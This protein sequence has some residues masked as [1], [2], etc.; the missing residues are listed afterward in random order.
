MLNYVS[1]FLSLICIIYII[2]VADNGFSDEFRNVKCC[3]V[4]IVNNVKYGCRDRELD[5]PLEVVISM[6]QV[7]IIVTAIIVLISNIISC[8]GCNDIEEQEKWFIFSLYMTWFVLGSILSMNIIIDFSENTFCLDDEN[9][10]DAT[11]NY[12]K[13]N[14]ILLSLILFCTIIPI[15]LGIL[16]AMYYLY[17]NIKCPHPCIKLEEQKKECDIVSV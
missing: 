16:I 5:N 9:T 12:E 8:C 15:S 1:G 7:Y 4:P 2:Y 13:F 6:S 10:I 11:W 14:F 17:K 3:S